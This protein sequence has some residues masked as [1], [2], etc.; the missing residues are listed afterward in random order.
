M[1]LDYVDGLNGYGENIVRLYDFGIED[2]IAFRDTL[3]EFINNEI[4]YIKLTDLSFIEARNCTLALF[5]SEADE[6]IISED[7]EN[8]FCAMTIDG[9]KRMVEL[10]EPFCYKETK[11]YQFLYELD[12]LTDFLFSPAGSWDED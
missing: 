7:D 11:S 8:F 12:I 10:I 4:P 3:V 6:G 1:K 9:Y 5:K 2:T